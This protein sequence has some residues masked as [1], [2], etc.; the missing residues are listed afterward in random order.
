MRLPRLAAD[1]AVAAAASMAAAV[2]VATP[3]VVDTGNIGGLRSFPQIAPGYSHKARLLQQAGFVFVLEKTV[4]P[5]LPSL[6]S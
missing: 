5:I 6:W 3:A 4:G 1:S 2:A